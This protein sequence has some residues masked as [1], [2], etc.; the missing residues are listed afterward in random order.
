M[1]NRPI[2]MAFTL[3]AAMVFSPMSA[4]VQQKRKRSI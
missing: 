2:F 3:V 4:D 1:R